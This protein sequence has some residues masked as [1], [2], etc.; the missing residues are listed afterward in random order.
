DAIA[1][2][3]PAVPATPTGAPTAMPSPTASTPLSLLDKTGGDAKAPGAKARADLAA[4]AL[5]ALTK[6][7]DTLLK[8]ITS[9]D[10]NQVVPALTGVLTGLVNYLAALLL[11]GGLPVPNLPGLPSLPSLPSLPGLPLP[12]PTATPSTS[13]TSLTSPTSPTS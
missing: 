13:P 2:V 10:V 1:K 7:L 4:D 9:G 3:S 11:S 6:A 5:A 8:A 12:V